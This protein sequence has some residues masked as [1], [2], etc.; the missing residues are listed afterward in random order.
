MH[1]STTLMKQCAARKIIQISYSHL[2]NS[3][4]R[5]W[6]WWWGSIQHTKEQ[7]INQKKR[8]RNH[9]ESTSTNCNCSTPTTQINVMSIITLIY[10]MDCIDRY[11][12]SLQCLIIWLGLSAIGICF[13]LFSSGIEN[14]AL[15]SAFATIEERTRQ[16]CQQYLFWLVCVCRTSTHTHTH[17]LI[18][19][20][21]L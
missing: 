18:E 20:N 5:W 19:S 7:Q 10:W 9:K 15:Y 16:E 11:K 14:I 12:V 2:L 21:I 17:I 8:E 4:R 3:R 6:W 1:E 13:V